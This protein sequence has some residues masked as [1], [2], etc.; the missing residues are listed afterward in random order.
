MPK[1]EPRPRIC[2]YEGS[3]YRT[4]FWEG[5]GRNYED[6]VERIALRRL[7]PE[8][9]RRLLEVGAGFGR[10]THEYDGYEQVVLMDYSF[11]Q[12]RYA[13]EHLGTSGRFVYVAADAY[14]LPFRDGVFDGTTI[15]RVIHHI[16]DVPAVLKQVRRVMTSNGVFI[17][18]YANKRNLKALLRYSRRQQSWDPNSL[19]PVEFVELN[20]DFHPD[21]M[22]AQLVNAGFALQRSIPVSFFRVPLL[23]NRLPTGLLAGLDGLLQLTGLHY[24]PSVFTRNAAVGYSPNNLEA[25]SIFVCPQCGADLSQ[26]DDTMVCDS[27]DQRWAIRDGIYD[28]K[29]PLDD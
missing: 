20:F 22:R 10:L 16:A 28:F 14:Q 21:Y 2:D 7:L 5:K 18:E 27:C 25:P 11:S 24:T 9:G 15:I 3:N 6:R 12:L 17:L 23:K 19:E 1:P 4:D 13:Q 29:A 26:V 8:H